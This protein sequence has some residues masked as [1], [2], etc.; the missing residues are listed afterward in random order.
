MKRDRKRELV[1]R[2]AGFVVV[3]YS[4]DQVTSQPD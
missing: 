1:L 4:W 2:S 3:R